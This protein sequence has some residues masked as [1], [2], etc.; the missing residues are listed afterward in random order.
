MID[1]LAR[2]ADDVL[3]LLKQGREPDAPALTLLVRCYR[4]TERADVREALEPAL[5]AVLEQPLSS[6]PV[7][8]RAGY[9]TMLAEAQ[10]VAEDERIRGAMDV[11]LASLSAS[12][13]AEA[14]V[15]ESAV[16]LDACLVAAV[17]LDARDI[18]SHAIDELERV[19]GGAYKPGE[20][21]LAEL[22]AAGAR[23]R[24]GDH[25]RGA[26]A[27]LTAYRVT[28]RLPYAMLAEELMQFARRSLWDDAA[29]AFGSTAGRRDHPFALN[30][31]AAS[32]Y[33]RLAS[34]HAA[35][36]YREAAVLAPDADYRADATRVLTALSARLPGGGFECAEYGLALDDWLGGS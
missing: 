14:R 35:D 15:E 11:L 9:L 32:V 25:V 3:H 36:D 22:G 28:S 2:L 12:W 31:G 8:A 34:L 26:S 13:G 24:L 30:C 6:L 10:A 33:C 21:L 7:V 20:G 23:G 27:L 16:G 4:A 5:G 19:I 1:D 17:V 29:G 18:I